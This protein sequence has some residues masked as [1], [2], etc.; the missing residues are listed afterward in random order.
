MLPSRR[1]L[2]LAQIPPPTHGQSVMV[3][4]LV[5]D[6]AARNSKD[7]VHVNLRLS[8]DSQDVGR[9]RP[10]KLILLAWCAVKALVACT[11]RGAKT[12]YYVPAPGKRGAIIRDVL[13]LS[14]LK[15]FTRHLILH[16]HAVGL[17][18]YLKSNPDDF[19][20]KRLLRLLKGHRLSICLSQST[21][22]DIRYFQPLEIAI[23]PNGIPD[24]CPEFP[25]VL[26][27]RR[28][29]LALRRFAMQEKAAP[30]AA[31]HLVYIGLCTRSKGIFEALCTAAAL[32]ANLNDQHACCPIILTIAGPFAS[33]AE[34]LEFAAAIRQSTDS[35]PCLI[36]PLFT[37][38]QP[39]FTGPEEKRKLLEMADLF[40]FPTRYENEGLPLTLL[41]SLAFGLPVLTT[42][43]RS[44]PDALPSDYSWM[45][46]SQNA[47]NMTQLAKEA[48]FSD[49]FPALREWFL[50]HFTLESHL[51]AIFHHLRLVSPHKQ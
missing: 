21:S 29:R 49:A 25:R 26:A 14:L 33:E 13:L 1:T 16:W 34:Q 43:W 36:R 48:L 6:I 22:V 37:V 4:H 42:R 51:S 7:F 30:P 15:P 8:K 44:I 46:D 12:I 10:A 17:G 50:L 39:G 18:D 3:G 11:L 27:A 9:M 38:H 31:I 41:E 2:I 20:G 47:L 24:P 35:L 28:A 45:A 23:I 40:I 19:W 5:G 32:T